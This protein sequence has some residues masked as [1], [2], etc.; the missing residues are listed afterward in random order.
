MQKK[1]P[2]PHSLFLS[3][4]D[5]VTNKSRNSSTSEQLQSCELL[6]RPCIAVA[7]Q[8]NC[9]ESSVTIF[10]Y[11]NSYFIAIPCR[12]DE[13]FLRGRFCVM[14]V[15]TVATYKV[16]IYTLILQVILFNVFPTGPEESIDR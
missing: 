10:G 8:V 7:D 9:G 2:D 16:K 11:D 14:F 5:Y 4:F 12:L 6:H 3:S 15:V 1:L 13:Y